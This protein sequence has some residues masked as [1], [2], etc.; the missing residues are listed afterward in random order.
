MV[1]LTGLFPE[2]STRCSAYASTRKA[3][4]KRNKGFKQTRLN[5]QRLHKQTHTNCSGEHSV[6]LVSSAKRVW[7]YTVHQFTK[8]NDQHDDFKDVFTLCFK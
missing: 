5:M 3:H 8:K 2:Q 7:E 4:L 6:R 1:F